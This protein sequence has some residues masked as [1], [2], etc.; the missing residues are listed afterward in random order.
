MNNRCIRQVFAATVF[1][2]VVCVNVSFAKRADAKEITDANRNHTEKTVAEG[3]EKT[4]E[5]TD[6]TEVFCTILN[7]ATKEWIGYHEV[8]DAFLMWL[9]AQYGDEV[10][11]SLAAHVADG[12]ADPQIWYQL[13]GNS[14]HVLWHSYCEYT[15]FQK[16]LLTGTVR[17]ECRDDDQTILRFAGDFN[18]AED[19]CTTGYMDSQA[20][21]INACFSQRLLDKMHEADILV[22]N[23]EFVYS[24]RGEAL[25]G[26]KYTFRAKPKQVKLLNEFGADLV[27]LANNHAYD[28]GEEALLD[29][30]TFLNEENIA[31]IGAGKNWQE[32]SKTVSYIANGRKI[33]FVSATEIERS[34]SFTKEATET[35]AG[36]I[37]TSDSEKFLQIVREA[38]KN[39]DYVIAV[40]HWGTEGAV[41]YDAFQ[42]KL[43]EKIVK[44]GADAIIGGHPHRLQGAGFILGVPVAYSLG[45]FWFSTGA[46]Y[47]A[48]AQL[49]IDREG[50][51]QLSYIPCIQK[52][53]TADLVTEEAE[54]KR[55]FEYLAAVSVKIGI[56]REG[57]VYDGTKESE[58]SG[59]ILYNS[60]L[61]QTDIL[62]ARDI[63]GNVI[64]IIGNLID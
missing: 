46:L 32:A 17:Q 11:K 59:E 51:I 53:L 8:D 25:L 50:A 7:N 22:M 3:T 62:G 61:A 63:E 12:E 43:A 39:N 14:I 33:A 52:N 58:P 38:D 42:Y 1:T 20:D 5:I 21:G 36:V 4:A 31:Y 13:T 40:M 57:R 47:S 41:K 16:D 9:D 54:M 34:A 56:D 27:A 26:K 60:D 18:L 23:N 37:K 19:W 64:D 48:L 55:Y 24:E 28:Y 29:T 45:N 6:L 44:A 30:L 15:G 10:I 2:A 35:S 49:T